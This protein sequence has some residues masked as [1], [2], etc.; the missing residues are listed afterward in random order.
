MGY[1]TKE[2]IGI[3]NAFELDRGRASWPR[4]HAQGSIRM[5]V[6]PRTAEQ[7]LLLSSITC[8]L[9]HLLIDGGVAGETRKP[10]ELEPRFAAAPGMMLPHEKIHT[11]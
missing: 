7:S 6:K 11:A 4:F 3:E 5:T 10:R 9:W 8:V 2:G 1:T